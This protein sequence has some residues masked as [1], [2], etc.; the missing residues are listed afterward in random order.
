MVSLISAAMADQE[1]GSRRGRSPGPVETASHIHFDSSS[2]NGQ[3]SV[4]NASRST[5]VMTSPLSLDFRN[6]DTE[7]QNL[8]KFPGLRN[9]PPSLDGS[10]RPPSAGDEVDDEE[11]TAKPF[12]RSSS[13]NSDMKR[14]KGAVY[15]KVGDRGV[16]K[17]HKFS[18]YETATRYYIVGADVMDKRFRILKIDRTADTGSLSIAEDEIVYTKKEMSQLLNAIDDGNKSTGGMKLRCSTWGLLGFIRF[19][20]AYYMLVVTKRSQVALIG[21]HFTYKVDATDLIPLTTG[22][23]S[24]FKP[25]AKNT[26]ETRFLGIMNN[27]DLTK[28]FYFSYSYDITRTLQHN[29]ITERDAIANGTTY[30]HSQNQNGMF[31]WNDYLLKPARAVLKNTYDWCLPV[32]HGYIDQ[33]GMPTLHFRQP[34]LTGTALS[35]YGRT[36]YIT[37]IA[38]RS[39]HFAGARF[40][41]RGANDLVRYLVYCLT[42]C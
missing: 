23:S 2:I 12:Q 37:V 27:L 28:S 24:R 21:G 13:L 39:R 14:N 8:P 36:V 1:D 3:S 25:D 19:T 29:I 11:C 5:S 41:K 16:C 10:R 35:I 20:G 31:V 26:E 30:P 7:E 32:I 9:A 15:E 33:A 22:S 4:D 18:L 38:R 34:L 40:L 17:M 42:S 6:T